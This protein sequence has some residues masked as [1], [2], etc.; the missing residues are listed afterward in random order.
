MKRINLLI[1]VV[2]TFL[3]SVF[4]Q[5]V[6]YLN[7][8]KVLGGYEAHSL[9]NKSAIIRDKYNGKYYL[10]DINSKSTKNEIPIRSFNKMDS[11]LTP[12]LFTPDNK[13]IS[14]GC[15]MFYGK[16]TILYMYDCLNNKILREINKI[17][18]F[19]ITKYD[20]QNKYYATKT[21]IIDAATDEVLL[22]IRAKTMCFSHFGGKIAYI[23][24]PVDNNSY[25][26]FIIVQDI[27]SKK[28]LKKIP[29][30][31]SVLY[32]NLIEFSSNDNLL[33]IVSEKSKNYY[34]YSSVT[35]INSQDFS[36][37]CSFDD[38]ES[39]Y[40]ICFSPDSKFLITGENAAFSIWDIS[41]GKLKMKSEVPNK[42][43]ITSIYLT[44][45][46]KNLITILG[47]DI[48]N[49][50]N[51]VIYYWD[52]ISMIYSSELMASEKNNP[53]L[54]RP[55]DEFETQVQY[56]QRKKE[57]E[58]FKGQQIE[59]Y[60]QDYLAN[61]EKIKYKDEQE[62]NLKNEKI[63]NSYTKVDL[64]LTSLGTY[65]SEEQYFPV[66]FGTIKEKL[67]IPIA[68]AKGLKDNLGS[69]KVRAYKQLLSDLT[70][71]EVFNIQVVHP[72]TGSVYLLRERKSTDNIA[73]NITTPI[74]KD[75]V[76]NLIASVKFIE[77]SGNNILDAKETGTIEVEIFNQ[78]VG[79][80][81]NIVT[82]LFTDV[83]SGVEFDREKML[84]EVL[85]G[86]KQSLVF[87]LKSDKYLKSGIAVFSLNFKEKNGFQPNPIKISLNTQDFKPPK[88]VFVEA[89]ISDNGNGIIEN[90]KII[91]VTALI[92]N[93]GQGK[94]EFSKAVFA[95][96]DENIIFT[97]PNSINQQLGTLMPGESK[98]LAF[99]FVVNN[100]Y[101][102]SNVLP[103]NLI[104]SETENEYGGNY[105]LNLEMRKKIPNTMNVVVEGQYS[106]G[107][108]I[109]EASLFSEI[110]KNIPETGAKNPNRFALI[111]GNEDYKSSQHDLNSEIN[112]LFAENDAKTLKEYAVKTL[113]VPEENITLLINA[114]AGRMNQALAKMN[115]I[116]KNSNGKAE[117]I[118]YYAGHGLPDENTKEPYLIPVDV[119]GANFLEGGIKLKNVYAKL[120][121]FP[122]KKVSVFIDACFSGGARNQG[123]LSARAVKIK[124]K[125]S[126]LTGNIVVFS[127]SSGEQSSLPYQ[128]KQHGMFTYY[129]LKKIQDTK[130]EISLK[131]LSDYVSEQ[132]SLQS[133]NINNKEQTPVVNAGTDSW[134]NWT[135]R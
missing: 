47:P 79:S 10:Y 102:G 20:F 37:K 73:N 57:G 77:P 99:S 54:F 27:E 72:I 126:A 82:Q 105:P 130:G 88:L 118:F 131:E 98:K 15:Q 85:P 9:D 80:A 69:V 35:I 63:R 38:E 113:G 106:K 34:H 16:K 12:I 129:L 107:T 58:I 76:P 23:E 26:G 21:S 48:V 33:A 133:V 97:T 70:T 6:K 36:Q 114:T 74:T 71:W 86:Q 84:P 100:N 13:I 42:L 111:I 94:A 43:E 110:D 78:G 65:N 4:A 96:N 127:A 64:S 49:S 52:F 124:P 56:E 67:H 109:I 104:L 90:G 28:I 29:I 120:T 101:K 135:L 17:G 14:F 112:V 75:A 40:S 132:V 46:Y 119:S 95:K 60:Y 117:L 22:N 50:G 19:E 44:S 30:Q 55:K 87:K 81:Q 18:E 122:S 115:L 66:N 32:D 61:L 25:E 31:V 59:K 89:G 1:A 11:H 39:I 53:N 2:F 68:E 92:Q 103:I 116:A 91:N 93:Q 41:N 8:G 134:G 45:D 123:L 24:P 62:I 5:D 7:F 51:C 83:S 128:D 125:E 3:S 108:T 121:E